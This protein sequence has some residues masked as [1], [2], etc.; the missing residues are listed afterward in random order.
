MLLY[1]T[2]CGE[3]EGPVNLSFGLTVTMTGRIPEASI[4]WLATVE[5]LPGS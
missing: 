2:L 5:T 3:I 1:V 4:L